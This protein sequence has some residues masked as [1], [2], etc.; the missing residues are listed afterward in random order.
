VHYTPDYIARPSIGYSRDNFG[1]G[2]FGG[3]AV[4]LSDIL[5]NHQL[6]FAG[7][8]NGRVSEAQL[9]AAYANM[10]HRINWVAGVSQEPYYFYEPSSVAFDTPAPGLNTF[11]TNVRRLVVRSAFGQAFY[12]I[13]RFER[14][15]GSLRF[16]NVDDAVLSILE[17][18]NPSSGFA[19]ADP[20]LVT[21]NRPG[22]N[23]L[24]PSV[25]L[26]FDNSLFGYTGPFYGRRWRF[27]I[28]QSMGDWNFTQITVDHRRYDKIVGPIVFSTRL[29]YFGRIGRDAD[30]FRIFAG[31][32]DLIRG[33]TSG[34]YRRHEC[35]NAND[36]NTQTGC[37]D[38]DR[39]VGTQLAVVSAELRFPILTP[40]TGA[41]Q[42]F[43]PIEG[44]IF[45][46]AGLAWEGGST[47]NFSRRSG[48]DPLQVRTPLS[49][50]GASIRANLF[51]FAIA[52]VDYAIPRD[53]RNVGGMWTL[54]L[55][56]AF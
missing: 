47:I 40:S 46:D 17:P 10:T 37:S 29:L 23:Y 45:Y 53:R 31:S 15:E 35:L 52:R 19:T 51:G 34:S 12:P 26:V 24:L 41:P 50:V 42:G 4:S 13:N 36:I 6:V 14:V 2:F 22:V 33:H 11:I 16:A 44:A 54:S 48:S 18:Y 5:G 32:T 43:P 56:P 28:G 3:T 7:Y 21:N 1:R 49:A 30:R 8:V 9:L 55:G 27:E 38:L 39:L 20:T 25:A